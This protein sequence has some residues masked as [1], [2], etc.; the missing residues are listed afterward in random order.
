ML[1]VANGENQGTAGPGRK[2]AKKNQRLGYWNDSNG[3]KFSLVA[4]APDILPREKLWMKEF[5]G[6]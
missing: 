4:A 2:I 3:E 5:S 6:V 1:C